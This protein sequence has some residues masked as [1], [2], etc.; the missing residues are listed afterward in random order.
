MNG[1]LTE[2]VQAQPSMR[3]REQCAVEEFEVCVQIVV[4]QCPAGTM[5]IVAET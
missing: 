2:Y 1:V 4:N 5:C 3:L